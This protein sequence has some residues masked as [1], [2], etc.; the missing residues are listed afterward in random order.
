MKFLYNKKIIATA[1]SFI[2]AVSMLSVSV[3]ASPIYKDVPVTH[4]AHQFISVVADRGLMLG[5]TS[6]NFRPDEML[7]KFETSKI[8]ARSAGFKY[9][10]I[11]AQ[12]QEYYD[13]CYEK[14]KIFLNQ[15]NSRFTRW[16]PSAD[17]EIAFLLE[18]EILIASDLNQFVIIGNNNTEQIRALSRGE[19]AV[20][21]TKLLGRAAQA[22]EYTTTNLFADDAAIPAVAKPYVY[23]LR[24]INIINGD[25][26]DNF[27]ANGAVTR[28]VMATMLA[29]ALDI[30]AIPPFASPGSNAGVSM[31]STVT[32]TIDAYYSNL[33]AVQILTGTNEKKIY[34]IST[35][36]SVHI[37]GFLRTGND[38]REGMAVIAVLNNDEIIDIR[39][40]GA[41]SQSSATPPA[42]TTVLDGTVSSIGQDG[43][44]RTINIEIK[45]VNPRDNT[46]V[47]DIRSYT[48]AQGCK[49]T[50][51]NKEILFSE[52]VRG[53]IVT[54]KVS[55]DT[56][57]ELAFED[58]VL[59]LK[60][61]RLKEKRYNE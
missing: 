33:N 6:A 57:Y 61:A 59:I 36:G 55:G 13:A 18:K 39:A 24:S 32:G 42:N 56:T 9:E 3:I 8:L 30:L 40:Q 35:G 53:D 44:T 16:N 37:D 60:D 47:A 58:R 31:V 46:I 38:L 15:Y 52:I 28:A 25:A 19:A 48:L 4:W 7:D 14:N 11:S 27:N 17:R 26:N 20:F 2:A 1:V 21:I 29:R 51:S 41:T 54:A 23:Y 5:D 50:R 34:R 45:T 12:E 10:N 43:T 22:L 49:I